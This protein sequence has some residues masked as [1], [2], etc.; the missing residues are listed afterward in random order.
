MHFLNATPSGPRA[1]L[2]THTLCSDG[3][4]AP[5]ELVAKAAEVGLA[6]LAITDHDTLLGLDEAMEA[7]ARLGV[8]IVT[9]SELSVT[10]GD[11]EVH[12][13]AYGFDPEHAGLCSALQRMKEG[14]E[15]RAREM[16][17]RLQKAGLDVAWEAV[18]Q[19]ARGDAIGRPH[20]ASVL[21]ADGY[22]E[23]PQEAFER[24]LKAG[25]LAFV[26][27]PRFEAADALAVV[28][29]AGGVGV[30]AH[31]GHWMA[32]GT[33]EQLVDVG[34][35]GIEVIHPSHDAM[36]TDYYRGVARRYGLLQTGGSDYHG[37]RPDEEER[38][39]TFTVPLERLDA[40]RAA[41]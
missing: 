11:E 34:L 41:A 32:T 38:F 4:L 33:I 20:V 5:A 15:R 3:Y 12:M 28:H 2:H 27:K 26:A 18:R 16:V 8:R 24:Y 40:L 25:Q 31:P 30:L 9:G 39:G 17:E 1:D 6:A 29:E 14:R 23:E 37:R 22:V 13:L 36:L 35:D 10:V 19:R 7:G 21:V